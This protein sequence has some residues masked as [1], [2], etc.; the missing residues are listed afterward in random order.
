MMKVLTFLAVLSIHLSSA[1]EAF[2]CDNQ[3]RGHQTFDGV[4]IE[5]CDL[6]DQW[7]DK[8]D[9][10]MVQVVQSKN[11]EDVLVTA[12]E[13]TESIEVGWCAFDHLRYG[14]PEW[15][16]S[17]RRV[18]L[19]ASQCKKLVKEHLLTYRN[20]EIKVDNLE[21]FATDL[22]MF[23]TSRN[24]NGGCWKGNSFNLD[25]RTFSNNWARSIIKVAVK[26]QQV[27]YNPSQDTIVLE[28]EYIP[29]RRRGHQGDLA[30]FYWNDID[31]SCLE[32]HKEVYS[33]EARLFQ[34]TNN[35]VSDYIL[36]NDDYNDIRFAVELQ[37]VHELCNSQ[38][39]KT[40]V[41]GTYVTY[42]KKNFLD[43]E[44]SNDADRI[45]SIVGLSTYNYIK[46]TSSYSN[47]MKAIA[48]NACQNS[49]NVL[50]NKIN[51]LKHHPEKMALDIFGRGF[52]AAVFA[53][54]VL[55]WKCDS[56]EVKFNHQLS[57]VSEDIPVVYSSHGKTK[58][59]F[60]DNK[61]FILKQHSKLFPQNTH[62]TPMYYVNKEWWCKRDK[63]VPCDLPKKFSVNI[64]GMKK[65]IENLD[66]A[67]K[68]EGGFNSKEER[69]AHRVN[70]ELQRNSPNVLFGITTKIVEGDKEG[71]RD[72]FKVP[73]LEAGL[74]ANIG[75]SIFQHPMA[76][77]SLVFFAIIIVCFLAYIFWT[78]NSCKKV[79]DF[80]KTEEGEKFSNSNYVW[81]AIDHN[82]LQVNI[83]DAKLIQLENETQELERTLERLKS[84]LDQ[85]QK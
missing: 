68:A 18:I 63:I 21:R 10:V 38:F 72:T 77:Q 73:D 6:A 59:A 82:K 43:L 24:E 7:Y 5:T 22:P 2:N 67:T 9:K 34:P 84:M 78:R 74:W 15:V 17:D 23:G 83:H 32:K 69:E 12:C 27:R 46:R 79:S 80:K 49:R 37:G 71:L 20:Q 65:A 11:Q 52:S 42:Y 58:T 64:D 41:A 56:I 29:M 85:S 57:E 61:S 81:A 19:T 35:D 28:G 13:V 51:L 44:K 62:N 66:K 26:Q 50:T 60:V 14:I 45:D 47:A 3:Y 25:G 75:K 70:L 48:R 4:N 36:V 8:E 40:N 33:G 31:G 76:I 39:F 16:M 55:V 30:S 1:F 54:S 53:G